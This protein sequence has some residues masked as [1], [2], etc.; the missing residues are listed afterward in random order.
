MIHSREAIVTKL[1]HLIH[2]PG[3]GIPGSG[4]R[5]RE[6]RCIGAEC[7]AGRCLKIEA[8]SKVCHVSI[9]QSFLFLLQLHLAALTSRVVA[10]Y[11]R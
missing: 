10:C 7:E 5:G 1:S 2:S 11:A 9:S 4:A 3:E 8:Y 6:R